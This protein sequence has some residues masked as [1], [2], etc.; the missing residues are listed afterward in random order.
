MS[1][2]VQ[3]YIAILV[4]ALVFF[5]FWVF[6]YFKYKKQRIPDPLTMDLYIYNPTT[7]VWVVQK[8]FSRDDGKTWSLSAV[9]GGRKLTRA[10]IDV[11]PK[12]TNEAITMIATMTERMGVPLTEFEK[13]QLKRLGI[14][15]LET[16]GR[17]SIQIHKQHLE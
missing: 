15:V 17:A 8:I 5:A 11:Y 2:S 13:A 14:A 3:R 4:I 6:K 1:E 16:P 9:I 12:L 10:V 7:G